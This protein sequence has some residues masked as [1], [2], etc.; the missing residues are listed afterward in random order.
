[1]Y[2]KIRKFDV[3]SER[4]F[5]SFL[6]EN[7]YSNLENCSFEVVDDWRRQVSGIDIVLTING[8]K[9]NVDEKL[10]AQYL[11]TEKSNFVL[12]LVTPEGGKGW[13]VNDNLQTDIYAFIWGSLNAKKFPIQHNEERTDY[14]KNF[15][16]EDITAAEVMFFE[17]RLLQSFFSMFGYSADKLYRIALEMRE[18]YSDSNKMEWKYLLDKENRKLFGVK[19][20]VYS[21]FLEEKPVCIVLC[22][23]FLNNFYLKKFI[24]SNGSCREIKGDSG[25]ELFWKRHGLAYSYPYKRL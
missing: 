8:K 10:A 13:F 3:E 9:I 18:R 11:N 2:S 19:G 15:A 1:M 25:R 21:P 7:L 5:S 24:V 12:E 17:K 4:N 23:K 16:R 6:Q 20:I 14:F 22:P